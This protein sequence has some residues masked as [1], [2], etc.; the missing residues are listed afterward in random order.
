M[1][2]SL[3]IINFKEKENLYGKMPDLMKATGKIIWCMAMA[4]SNGVTVKYS[5]VIM[6][7]IENKGKDNYVYLMEQ[8]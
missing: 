8:W 7:R 2:E 1:R 5:E 6:L 4:F 3:V